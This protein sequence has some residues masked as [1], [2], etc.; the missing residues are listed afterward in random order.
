[1]VSCLIA[2]FTGRPWDGGKERNKYE[3]GEMN[4]EEKIHVIIAAKA[5][6]RNRNVSVT[7]RR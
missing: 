3:T 7:S 5:R 2:R 1:M 6:V 4:R